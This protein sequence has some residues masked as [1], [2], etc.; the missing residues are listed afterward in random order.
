LGEKRRWPLAAVL[1]T[2]CFVYF[3]NPYFLEHY[4]LVI[5]PAVMLI[6]L[7]GARRLV[8]GRW[9]RQLGV[10]VTLAIFAVSLTS[11]YEF[12]Q[13]TEPKEGEVLTDGMLEI[14]SPI[15]LVNA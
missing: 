12:K 9:S 4:P 14:P 2:F 11:L 5:C 6:V 10:P 13:M 15:A 1:A 7:A 8:A 3:F